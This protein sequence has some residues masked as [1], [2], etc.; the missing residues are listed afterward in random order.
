MA[1][2]YDGEELVVYW[3]L[4]PAEAALVGVVYLQAAD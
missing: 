1:Q 3:T 2:E 4:L